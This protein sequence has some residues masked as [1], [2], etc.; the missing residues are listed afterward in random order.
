MFDTTL[1]VAC[2]CCLQHMVD[3]AD[4]SFHSGVT[5]TGTKVTTNRKDFYD[6]TVPVFALAKYAATTGSPA[7]LKAAK[8]A[9]SVWDA[10]VYDSVNGGYADGSVSGNATVTGLGASK[11]ALNAQRSKTLNTQLHALLM[12]MDLAKADPSFDAAGSRLADLVKVLTQKMVV[13][14]AS[15]PAAAGPFVAMSC[16]HNYSTCGTGAVSFGL[17]AEW[18]WY[19]DAAVDLLVRQA[20]MTPAAA[21]STRSVLVSVGTAALANSGFDDKHGG[22]FN[23]G[24]VGNASSASTDKHWWVQLESTLAYFKL[25]QLTGDIDFLVKADKTLG[26]LATKLWD[27]LNGEVLAGADRSGAVL[28]VWDCGTG[29]KPEASQ[30]K[31]CGGK[32]SWHTGRALVQ[33]WSWLLDEGASGMSTCVA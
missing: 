25:W 17:T 11:A 33:L 13:N 8:K 21:V 7:A 31:A 22:V 27:P 3:R 23:A 10:A 19:V 15:D 1:P 14:T 2:C 9:W 4:G 5:Q 16:A 20:R 26:F 32:A 24:V 29:F 28:K 6:Q 12:V 18:V 30:V